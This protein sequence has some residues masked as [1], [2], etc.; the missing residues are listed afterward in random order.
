MPLANLPHTTRQR[1]QTS[2]DMVITLTALHHCACTFYK[3]KHDT[4]K[5]PYRYCIRRL[6]DTIS[7]RNLREDFTSIKTIEQKHDKFFSC[8]CQCPCSK[9]TLRTPKLP[10]LVSFSIS[11]LL[12][13]YFQ[14]KGCLKQSCLC[15]Q[16]L[17]AVSWL[18]IGDPHS[19]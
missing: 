9:T 18:N 11:K 7:I 10:G 14:L 13:K 1:I 15:R 16:T 2:A 8:S 5:S 4:Q 12:L 3:L 19:L 17:T 6:P